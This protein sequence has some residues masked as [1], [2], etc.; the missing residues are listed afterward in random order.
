MPCSKNDSGMG[1]E[2]VGLDSYCTSWVN[3]LSI[4]SGDEVMLPYLS[5]VRKLF[6][7]TFFPHMIDNVCTTLHCG[8]FV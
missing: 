4:K 5:V 2:W 6:E 3:S 1:I 7:Y 8:T